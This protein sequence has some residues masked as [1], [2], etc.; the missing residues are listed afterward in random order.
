MRHVLLIIGN[1]GGTHI[2]Q[3][4]LDAAHD[5]GREAMLERSVA[6]LSPLRLPQALAWRVGRRPLRLRQFSRHIVDL[7]QTHGVKTMISTGIAPVSA[8][9]LD[10]LGQMGV[11]RINFSTDDPWNKAHMAAWFFDALRRYDTV[12]TPRRANVDDFSTHG[13][14]DVRYLPFGYDPQLFPPATAMTGAAASRQ[15]LFVG[16]ADQDR[17]QFFRDFSAQGMSPTLVGGY[18]EKVEDLAA[19]AI[20]QLSAQEL[21]GITANAAV[22]LCLV[23]RANRDGHVMRSLEIPAVGGFMIAE[24]TEEHRALFGAEGENT[25]Y[26]DSPSQAASKAAWA[27]AHPDERRRMSNSCHQLI[28]SGGHTY[29]DRLRHMLDDAKP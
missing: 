27:L 4:L 28:I 2:G 17:I 6:A 22:N 3:S 19:F 14:A 10:A 24:D 7:C 1:S 9:A 15:I 8:N 18:W 23:R 13:C 12:F 16:G 26:F 29:G 20:G 5:L 11:R 21:R 25:L